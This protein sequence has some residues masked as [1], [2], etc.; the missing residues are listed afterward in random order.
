MMTIFVKNKDLTQSDDYILVQHTSDV[1]EL[2]IV[3]VGQGVSE[4]N[5]CL[6]LMNLKRR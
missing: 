4:R 5:R 2:V 6:C 3:D 1:S